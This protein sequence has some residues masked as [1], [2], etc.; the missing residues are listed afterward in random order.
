MALALNLP[1]ASSFAHPAGAYCFNPKKKKTISRKTIKILWSKIAI[2]RSEIKIFHNFVEIFLLFLW[3][4]GKS[5]SIKTIFNPPPAPVEQC[6]CSLSSN[7]GEKAHNIIKSRINAFAISLPFKKS[8]FVVQNFCFS[9]DRK[10]FT[11]EIIKVLAK[12]QLYV[13][14]DWGVI[15]LTKTFLSENCLRQKRIQWFL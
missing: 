1:L 15:P 6:F 13:P 12:L 3:W 2:A 7:A 4:C 10:S 14:F 11:K 8:F 9:R 5:F